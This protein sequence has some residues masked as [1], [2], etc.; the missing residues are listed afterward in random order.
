[1]KQRENDRLIMGEFIKET[2]APIK[3]AQL[4]N[5]RLYPKISRLRDTSTI[6]GSNIHQWTYMDR[7]QLVA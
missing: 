2:E 6:D 1:M 5:I 3:F 7:H 4:N